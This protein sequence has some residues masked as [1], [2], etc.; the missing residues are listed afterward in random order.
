M[1]RYNSNGGVQPAHLAAISEDTVP[2]SVPPVGER[3]EG[4]SQIPDEVSLLPPSPQPSASQ[5]IVS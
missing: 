3:L 4:V 5:E 1:A 2:R